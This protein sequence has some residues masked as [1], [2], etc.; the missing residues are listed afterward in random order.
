[1]FT[2]DRQSTVPLA[3]Q[4]EQQLRRLLGHGQLAAG[5]RLPSVR[6]LAQQLGVSPNTVV[7]EAGD[8]QH[9]LAQQSNTFESPGEAGLFPWSRV[10]AGVDVDE[11]VKDARQQGILLAGGAMFSPASRASPCLRLNV[12]LSQHVR[13][14]RYLEQRLHALAQGQGSLHPL[15][16]PGASP[17]VSPPVRA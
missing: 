17:G 9:R 15:A 13:L 6:R 16:Q 2:L 1:M 12:V 3:A 4:I 8:E 14:M 11:L 5:A 7:V 10:P